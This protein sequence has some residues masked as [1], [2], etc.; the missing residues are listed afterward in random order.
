[1]SMPS[2]FPVQEFT[3]HRHPLVMI[4]PPLLDYWVRDSINQGKPVSVELSKLKIIQLIFERKRHIIEEV[5]SCARS[6]V[7]TLEFS[8]VVLDIESRVY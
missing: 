6:I 2:R 5:F 3:I 1:M 8:F 4:T 7:Y